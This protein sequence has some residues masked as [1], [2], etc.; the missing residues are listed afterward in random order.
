MVFRRNG[1]GWLTAICGGAALLM[2]AGDAV[3]AGCLDLPAQGEG[4]V[5]SVIDPRTL[6]L[7][8]GREV[9]LTGIELA[10]EQHDAE[11]A[12][13]SSLALGRRVSLHGA[14]DGPDRYG[15]QWAFVG[16]EPGAELVQR[17]LLADGG[18]LVGIDAMP[19]ECRQELLAAEAGA[20][21]AAVGI[22]M[23]RDVIK[24]AANSGDMVT[25]IGRFTVIEGRITSVRE[26]GSTVYLNFGGR[27]TRGFAVTISRRIVGLFEAAG[28]AP[29]SLT[30][31]RI[32]VRGWVEKRAGASMAVR[33][34]GQIERAGG[35]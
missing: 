29:K 9:R 4:V 26:V 20:R 25:R 12:A 30:G 14:D 27:W 5:A 18:A 2:Q 7:A 16:A 21:A 28:L 19:A 8:D 35:D 11:V 31:Q 13:L 24:N 3:A 15:R 10:R 1:T 34:V 17:R 33:D 22:W 6:R 23:A 32:R